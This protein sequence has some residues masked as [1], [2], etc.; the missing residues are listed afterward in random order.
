MYLKSLTL[1][2]FKSFASATTLNFEP[3]I[4][5]IVG[6]NGS[7][8][9][10]IVDALAWVMGEQG[11]KHLRGAKMEDVIFAGTAG[12]PALGRAEVVLTIDN[13]DGALPID[14]TEVTISRTL[15]RS[16]G[17][18]Y[19]I[20]GHSARLLDVQE[21]LSDTGMGREMHVIVGQGQ[22]E[23][24]LASSPEM[25]RGYIEEAAGVLKHR[26]RREK[27]ARKLE[28][29]GA[30]LDRLTDLIA[31]I[32]R[33]LKPLGRQAAL[34]RKAGVVQAVLR[35]AK[36][37]LLADELTTETLALDSDRRAERDAARARAQAQEDL[38]SAQRAEQMAELVVSQLVPAAASAQEHWTAASTLA[39][40]NRATASVSAERMRR[41]AADSPR[42]PG[43]DPGELESQAAQVR[44]QEQRLRGE[45]DLARQ[46]QELARAK[47]AAA[48]KAHELAEQEFAREVRALA[49]RREGRAR[50]NGQRASVDAR[51]RA[52]TEEAE[53]LTK[54]RDEALA[55]A[56]DADR[57]FLVLEGD[58]TGLG[59]GESDL[60]A[61]YERVAT[62]V[63]QLEDR[64]GTLE[65]ESVEAQ[66]RVSALRARL[67]AL[68]L[69]LDSRDGAAGL[70][71]AGVEGIGGA[72][73]KVLRVSPG[74]EA[75][76]AAALGSAAEAL[77]ANDAESACR[78]VDDSG[79]RQLGRVNLVIADPGAAQNSS[80]E[81]PSATRPTDLPQGATPLVDLVETEPELSGALAH[82]LAGVVAVDDVA[83]AARLVGAQPQLR[84]VTRRG[85]LLSQ[86]LA[87]GGGE[88][89]R[90]AIE[91]Q[92]QVSRTREELA[93]AEHD[94]E[95]LRFARQGLD[96]ELA[97]ARAAA[98]DAL[99]KLN[100]SDAAMSALAEQL[101]NLGQ[102]ARAARSE[103]TRLDE[104]LVK[105][106]QRRSRD[107]VEL[108]TVRKRLECSSQETGLTDPDP[109]RRDET[110]LESGRA[111]QRETDALLAVR[112]AEERLSSL[113][114]RA[115]SLLRAASQERSARA[116]AAARAERVRR[117]Q[118][119]AR[120]VHAATQWLD[121]EMAQLRRAVGLEREQMDR[122]RAD[123]EASLASA[124]RL[125]SQRA[126]TLAG[127]V[128]DAHR[129]E[130][131]HVEQRMR[132]EALTERAMTEL[133]LDGEVLMSEYG[134]DR[135][136]PVLAH[137]DGRAFEPDEERP[138]PVPFDREQQSSRLRSAQRALDQ[139]GRI[140]PLALEEFDALNQRHQFL[141][142]QLADLQRTRK[143]L[144]AIIDEVDTRVQQVFAQAYGDVE[145]TFADI[146]PRLFPGGEGRL[147]L[148]DA[149]DV[150][151]AG[152]DIE[153]RPAGKRLRRM[154]LLSGGER[155][156]VSVAFL[157]SLFIARPSPFYILDEVEAALDDVNLS[158]LLGIY[159]E[160]RKD[161]Q[162]LVI[163]HQKRT[164]EKADALYGVTM[165][166]DGVTTVIS[167]RL[168]D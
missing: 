51:L 145:R 72:L 54:R 66:R 74:W 136:V 98:G 165:R 17:S 129:D 83:S 49:D 96:E 152:V 97:R 118:A 159:E 80:P 100:E 131:A 81:P 22:L 93:G 2:G 25:R 166:G 90:S 87:G 112:T 18:Q 61:R 122:A 157:F 12:R 103:A 104:A 161:S 14:Y 111:R 124:R 39:E 137:P 55:R 125:R 160:L 70:L 73:S 30:N 101:S 59:V 13:T 110:A 60:D 63:Q 6:P 56:E 1:R 7:G 133:G 130:V 150:N 153:A 128:A 154:S 20:N 151:Q 4:T 140:N 139:L 34:A 11:A 168:A 15:F 5:A 75:A 57:A 94:A 9:S 28:S 71:E 117:E 24:I 107:E 102:T 68:E 142:E 126:D 48:E 106:Q 162:L 41:G 156:L 146:F 10:N 26:R 47:R 148:T 147:V 91:L 42:I 167:Q 99:E 82:L 113:S 67:D 92:A 23:Q 32:R 58:I 19:A 115:D 143:D 127:L 164:M 85:E 3:G 76:L 95:R 158:R 105:A 21:L 114:G 134:P 62:R 84:A 132:I 144:Q 155:S 86:W 36:A 64:G 31:E 79:V 120:A 116:Q 53:R 43:R 123:A 8:K 29:T 45:L 77:V 44:E 141:A 38:E 135:P 50:L 163:T 109:A 69:G 89:D 35:D 37:R 149:T 40:R 108:A 33:Q 88:Q 119:V 138:E 121:V 16:G 46:D 27:A 65:R 52:G 78:V